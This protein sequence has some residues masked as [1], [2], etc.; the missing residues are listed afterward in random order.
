MSRMEESIIDYWGERCSDFNA[1]CAT[2]QV[3][4]LFD[5]LPARQWQD[6]ST[7]PKDWSD[8]LLHVPDLDSD[9]RTVCEGYFDTDAER[10]VSP[11]FGTIQPTHWQPL[12]PAP[13]AKP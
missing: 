4:A 1:E 10:W 7:A 11:L 8:M 12:P 9:A 13:E 3:W 5:G 2:C 6:I